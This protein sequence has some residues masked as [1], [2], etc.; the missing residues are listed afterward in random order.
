MKSPLR[1][2]VLASVLVGALAGAWPARGESRA[3]EMLRALL[4]GDVEVA[5]LSALVDQLGADEFKDREAATRKLMASPLLPPEVIQHGLA[6]EE[7][8][9]Q[10]RMQ[11]IVAAGGKM[12]ASAAFDRALDLVLEEKAE[13]QLARIVRV[14]ETALRPNDAGRAERAAAVTAVPADDALAKKLS[15]STAIP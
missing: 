14:L 12:G 4:P 2:A 1:Q 15:E 8:E 10:S 6:S 11:K 5:K 3:E 9:V 13:G 7:P